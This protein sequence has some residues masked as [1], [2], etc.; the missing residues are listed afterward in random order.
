MFAYVMKVDLS[1]APSIEDGLWTLAVCKGLLR[2]TAKIG[3]VVMGVASKNVL[4]HPYLVRFVAKVTSKITV[5][6]YHKV[7]PGA[8]RRPDQFYLTG[9]SGALVHSGVTLFHN[10]G[11]Q[12][13]LDAQEKD[14]EGFVLQSTN[15]TEFHRGCMLQFAPFGLGSVLIQ[16]FAT[17][18]GGKG[19]RGFQKFPVRCGTPLDADIQGILSMTQKETR[20]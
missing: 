16:Q 2:T 18:L 6:E 3:D 7:D 9:P 12:A 10:E 4:Q 8:S 20:S 17:W 14:K 1:V 5:L 15:F 19:R 13:S 11:T